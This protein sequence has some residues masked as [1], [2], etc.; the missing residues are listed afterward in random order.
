MIPQT[1]LPQ[2]KVDDDLKSDPLTQPNLNPENPTTISD[3]EGFIE[4]ISEIPIYKP[5]K[6]S[7]SIKIYINGSTYRL[8]VYDYKN[9]E[10]HYSPLT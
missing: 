10:W 3:I 8:Y 6:L 9:G 1:I 2:N 5:R 4:V 7:E